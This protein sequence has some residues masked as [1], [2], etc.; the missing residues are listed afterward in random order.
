MR[1]NRTPGKS[2]LTLWIWQ[3]W[4]RVCL[5]SRGKGPGLFPLFPNCVET[6]GE[7]LALR[8]ALVLSGFPPDL[9]SPEDAL[10]PLPLGEGKRP[11]SAVTVW[12]HMSREGRGWAGGQG[13]MAPRKQLPLYLGR[14]PQG[15]LELDVISVIHRERRE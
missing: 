1:V 13:L 14:G 5:E 2:C 6:T 10:L 3:L 4:W 9:S 11:C 12:K 7:L 8:A 15:A